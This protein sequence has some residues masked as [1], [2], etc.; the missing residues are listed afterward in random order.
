MGR[1]LLLGRVCAPGR[2]EVILISHRLLLNN[3]LWIWFRQRR[4]A[5][6]A[7]RATSS[8]WLSFSQRPG[9]SLCPQMGQRLVS[10]FYHFPQR[11]RFQLQNLSGRHYLAGRAI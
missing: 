6:F 11:C 8:P 9:P 4:I 3:L 5:L 7:F 10:P 1:A 2:L